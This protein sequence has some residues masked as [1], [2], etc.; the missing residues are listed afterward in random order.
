MVDDW[1]DTMISDVWNGN[2]DNIPALLAYNTEAFNDLYLLSNM[3]PHLNFFK[4][5][6]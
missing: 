2:G 1:I 5:E 6:K 4:T 3:I